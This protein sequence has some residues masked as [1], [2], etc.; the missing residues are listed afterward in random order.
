[1]L[2]IKIK[3]LDKKSIFVIIENMTKT[4]KINKKS[5]RLDPHIY[6]THYNLEIHP[7]LLSFTFKGHETIKVK[8]EKEINKITLHSKD[9]DIETV[10]YKVGNKEQFA[11]R[12]IYDTEKETATFF[13]KEKIKKGN[14]EISIT[15]M[16]IISDSLRGFYRSRYE[17]DGKE[18]H[19]ATTQFEA[20]DARRCFPCFDEPA[21]KAVFEVSLI[22]EE[23]HEA[24]SNTLPVEVR[25]HSA[26]YKITKFA[27]SPKMSTYLLAFIIGD[28][29]Y[30]EGHTKDNILI[31]VFT[32][33]GKK[34]QAKFALEVAI[35]S[36][37][38]FNEYF[39]IPYPM[40]NLDLITIQ[41]FEPAGMENWG[42]ITFRESSLLIDAEN[43]SLTNKQWVATTIAHEIA[44]QWFGN[45]VTMHWWTDLWLNEGFAS[46]MEK[47]CTNHI[48]PHWHVWDLY[49]SNGRYRNAIEIDSLKTSHPIEVELHHPN[50]IN[51]TFDMVSYEKGTAMIRMLANYL[52]E[53][54][55]RKGLSYYLKKHS[56]KNTRTNDL[57]DAFEKISKKPV[58]KIMNSWTSQMGFPVISVI[59]KNNGVVFEQEKFFSSR[60]TIKEQKNKCI[61]QVP[62]SYKVDGKEKNILLDKKSIKTSDRQIG[63]VNCNEISFLKVKY[64]DETLIK[65]KE[66]I[67]GGRLSTVDKLG[68]IRDLFAL[69]EG[70]YIKTSKAL[71]MSLSFVNE[72]EYIIWDEISYGINKVYNIIAKENFA[73]KYKKY[74][75]VIYG[76]IIKK[77]DFSKKEGEKSSD[78]LLRSLIISKAAFAENKKVIREAKQIFKDRLIKP[79]DPDIKSVIYGI[80]AS[81]GGV[82]EWQT[83]KKMY[84][85]E[86]LQ[87]EKERIAKAMASFKDKTC[88]EKT[89]DFAISKEV[90][91]NFAPYLIATVWHN[92]S[93]QD[94]A[95]RFM[96]ENWAIILKRYG[97]NG[98]LLSRLVYMLGNHTKLEDLK[99]AKKFFSKHAAPGAERTLLQAYERIESNAAWLKDDRKDIEGWLSKNY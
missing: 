77:V 1:M 92:I 59:N 55:F 82:K 44:H 88:I 47:V 57:W 12:I 25:E 24:I 2:F 19:I 80:V 64:N 16:G 58:R 27:P 35:K 87:E 83:F 56:Y 68:I 15:W 6:P 40:P 91:D 53:E 52:G 4:K 18:K 23:N 45:L 41:D 14:G 29:E 20:T 11:S 62:L 9:L 84:K 37:E 10:K 22:T 79:I 32:T 99:D 21:H 90:R 66:E 60:I 74:A 31:R 17:I 5:V 54:S 94:I 43:S 7:D 85:E 26:G 97:E 13:F 98:L 46:Y 30:I 33:P 50:E 63:K 67:I 38:F 65:L 34:H 71:E 86:N 78:T 93:G 70:G 42:A 39:D 72:E 49:L 36:V 73:D 61:W 69:A 3:I 51:E 96:K 28:F 48:F 8:T 76:Q 81:T 95:W 75:S 89:L